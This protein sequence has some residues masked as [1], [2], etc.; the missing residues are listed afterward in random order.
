MNHDEMLDGWV[1][2]STTRRRPTNDV[3]AG[4]PYP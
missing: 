4:W 1:P 2:A 3:P